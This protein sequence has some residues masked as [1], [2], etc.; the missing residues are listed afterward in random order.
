MNLSEI[1]HVVVVGAGTMGHA[2][3]QVYA[4]H[5]FIV[6]LVDLN[7]ITLKRASK[8]INSNLSLLAELK[9]ISSK[10]NPAQKMTTFE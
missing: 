4:Q 5:G 10:E 9:K 8:L 1:E 2:I 7:P 6:D 3:A